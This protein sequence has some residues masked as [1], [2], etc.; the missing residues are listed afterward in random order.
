MANVLNKY[1]EKRY[2]DVI[3]G[4]DQ[5]WLPINVVSDYYT[6]NWVPD[7]IN[8]ISYATSFGIS[9]IPNK[10]KDK[11]SFFLKRINHLSVREQS[12]VKICKDIADLD[13]KLV[14]DP[15]L[16]LSKE[17]WEEIAV[18]GRIIKDKYILCYF[19]GNSIEYRKFAERLKKKTGFLIVSLNHIDE[20]VKY[21]DTYCDIAPYDVGP[22]EWINLIKNAEFVLTDSFHGTVFSIIN[23]KKFF[24]FR[25]YA[26]NSKVS[27][28]T[29]INSLLH[30]FGLDDRL[31]NGDEPISEVINKKIDYQKVNIIYSKFS[32]DSKQFLLNS[33]KFN[34]EHIIKHVFFDETNKEDCCGCSAC[35]NVCPVHAITMT[36]DDEGFIY[37]CVDEKKCINCGK[38]KLVCK[39]ENPIREEIKNQKGYILQYNNE[40]IL[41]ES[42]SGGA[43]TAISE[44][45]IRKGGTVFGASFDNN[46]TV[47][48]TFVDKIADLKIFRNSK[49]VQSEIGESYKNVKKFLD[50]NRFVCFSGTPCQV[51]GLKSYLYSYGK[52]YIESD[53]L[54]LIDI[55]CRAVPSPKMLEIYKNIN[56]EKNE[57][58]ESIKFR[59]KEP[60]GYD[61]SQMSMKTNKKKINNGVETDVYLRAFF[62]DLSDR[63]SCYSCKFKKRY[64]ESDITLWDCFIAYDFDK[65]FDN[66]KGATRVL[67]HSMK[68]EKIINEI[69]NNSNII[70]KEFDANKII[71]GSKELVRS[72]KYNS[73]RKSFFSDMQNMSNE[74]FIKKWFKDTFKVK[75]ERIIRHT[76]EKLGIYSK[77]KRI[78]KKIVKRK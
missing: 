43:F 7:P 6:L 25:R 20:F 21:S 58:I 9:E 11:Y 56:L 24:T 4:S 48:H 27:T 44:Y 51:E 71:K 42:T 16:L 10:Y 45:I 17:E 60:Y 66:N 72:V 41:M 47:K 31:L 52:K 14:C 36:Q 54:L 73:N 37:P 50:E 33:L 18:K 2:S 38:C 67:T 35:M 40:Q 57:K 64:R 70:I 77:T 49:Y 3:V 15:T 19:L 78:A 65:D 69:K 39:I 53:K 46:F 26:A 55:V 22:S 62:D 63:P 34:K 75:T 13:A 61:Y 1:A 32:E 68:G 59:D 28:N 30:I 74:K 12:G 29:R 8:K 76:T 5:L 23:N